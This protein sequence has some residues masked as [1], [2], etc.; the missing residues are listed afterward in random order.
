MPFRLKDIVIQLNGIVIQLNDKVWH[1]IQAGND[2][3]MLIMIIS[4][5]LLDVACRSALVWL[6]S[7]V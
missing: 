1:T 2:V 5:N 7:V 3:R 6:P 4:F